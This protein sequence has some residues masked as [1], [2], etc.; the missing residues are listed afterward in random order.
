MPFLS[1]GGGGEGIYE[2]LRSTKFLLIATERA[3][4]R[5]PQQPP[6]VGT[7]GRQPVLCDREG[8][9]FPL[10]AGSWEQMLRNICLETRRESRREPWMGR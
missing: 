3:P 9:E 8:A 4:Q 6:A 5:A 7:R 10:T 1:P 2:T